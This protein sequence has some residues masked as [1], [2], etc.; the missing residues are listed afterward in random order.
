MK[1][2]RINWIDIEKAIGIFLI[3]F[4][5]TVISGN[6]RKVV[7]SFH[8]QLFF[9][10]SGLCF[11]SNS[12]INFIKNKFKKMYLPYI[13]ISLVSIL[14]Y[15][16]LGTIIKN[17]DAT[18]N[19]SNIFNNLFGMIYCNSNLENMKWNQP[20]WFIPCLIVLTILINLIEVVI[21]KNNK[22]NLYRVL[23]MFILT[24]IGN[25]L[26]NVNVYLPLHLETAMSMSIWFYMGYIFKYQ[27]S[28]K[29]IDSFIQKNKIKTIIGSFCVIMIAIF[30]ALNNTTVSV[31]QDR[32]GNYFLYYLVTV[33]FICI[34]TCI[35]RIISE[36]RIIE[37]VGRNTLYIL[38]FHKFPILIFQKI[39]PFSKN[40]LNGEESI[41][42]II[43]AICISIF[44]IC[45]CLII[46]YVIKNLILKFK[47]R[48]LI[49]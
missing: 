30:L 12:I 38:L 48:K 16:V 29:K 24:T 5:H 3:V 34:I 35:S 44:T 28:S 19:I 33:I 31:R 21:E 8:V 27:I 22:K 40:I 32:Y 26:S 41:N 13:F 6:I 49:C 11:K 20:L 45:S 42:M 4:G 1:E 43:I 15:F 39:I 18:L 23:I 25:I 47:R 37:Y 14:I 2:K 10:L 36:N 9:F 17:P 7:F 46:E